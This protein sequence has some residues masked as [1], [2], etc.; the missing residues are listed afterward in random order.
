VTGPIVDAEEWAELQADRFGVLVATIGQDWR[1][2][3][4]VINDPAW[5][6]L[7]QV[8][9]LVAEAVLNSHHHPRVLR[10]IGETLRWLRGI[11]DEARANAVAALASG[12]LEPDEAAAARVRELGGWE[13]VS[14]RRLLFALVASFGLEFYRWQL[15]RDGGA[16]AP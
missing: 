5:M 11:E 12:E 8:R 14:A 15:L 6:P 9:A 2:A 3:Q 1:A 7:G 10:R 13:G 4:R 16:G